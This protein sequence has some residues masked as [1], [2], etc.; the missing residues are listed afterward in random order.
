MIC[1]SLCMTALLVLIFL[2]AG[3]GNAAAAGPIGLAGTEIGL[4]SGYRSDRLD[5]NISGDMDGRN[6]TILSELTWE[7]L[8]TWQARTTLDVQLDRV[9]GWRGNS[10]FRGEFAYGMIL[11]GDVRDSDYAA[12]RRSDEWSRSLSHSDNG[13]VLDLTGSWGPQLSLPLWPQLTLVPRVGY[14]FSILGL[15][16]KG[17]EQVVSRPE[18]TPGLF[19]PPPARGP[20]PGL[21]SS[22]TAYWFGPFIGMSLDYRLTQRMSLSLGLEYHYFEYF[23]EADWNLRSE[24]AHPTSFEH[25]A[26]GTGVVWSLTGDYALSS[27]WQLTFSGTYRNW[28]TGHGTDR[29]FFADGRRGLSRLNQVSWT[30][31]DMNCG[32]RWRF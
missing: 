15:T 9:L 22:Y 28:R 13:Y 4:T 27:R 17:G 31:Y 3:G 16:M 25:E 5:W 7:D 19:S 12:D 20:I 10:L 26:D 18:L 24:F 29:T 1:R 6:P 21:D 8:E 2:G 30:S 23:A 14:G 32:V 11:D